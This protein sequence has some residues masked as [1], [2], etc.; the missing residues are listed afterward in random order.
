MS[1]VLQV[2]GLKPKYWT[3]YNFDLMMPLDEKLS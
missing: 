1:L 3:N 2:F